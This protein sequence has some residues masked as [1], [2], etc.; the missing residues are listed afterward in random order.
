MNRL[1]LLCASL[2]AACG[3]AHEDD[4]NPAPAPEARYDLCADAVVP[5]GFGLAWQ[6][7]NHRIS[8]WEIRVDPSR[9]ERCSGDGGSTL[10]ATYVGGDWT[11]GQS[12][13]DVPV[14]ML[15]Y[16]VVAPRDPN[17]AVRKPQQV[18]ATH[19][20][21]PL[22]IDPSQHASTVA[23]RAASEHPR[24]EVLTGLELDTDVPQDAS[25][26]D[27]YDP[28]HG[29]TSRG[30]TARVTDRAD[31]DVD[32][33]VAFEH[34]EA[35]RPPMN[36]A[37]EHARTRAVVGHTTLEVPGG[38][39]TRATKRIRLTYPM[40]EALDPTP[41]P[42]GDDAS[43]STLIEG[44]PGYDHGMV[45]LTGVSFSLFPELPYGDYI[46]E[47]SVRPRK[48][49]YD[50]DTGRARLLL[51]GYASN[52]GFLTMAGMDA[53]MTFDLVLV[54]WNGGDRPVQVSFSSP[55]DTGEAAFALPM[56]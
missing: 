30:I 36:A 40:Q 32:V 11:T 34:G 51:D 39:F 3:S 41:L 31:G 19:R 54:Q 1:V 24:V 4:P 25:Y 56:E 42:H 52:S 12:A 21:T 43:L 53:D 46:R 18:R 35:D 17:G 16:V 47:L 55:F 8:R 5:N 29:Y 48:V 28:A 33:Q 13:T 15:D 2:L 10:H 50:P 20:S 44:V 23:E 14:V 22:D 49:R 37:I 27:D 45:L 6:N 7:L 26:P 38:R 9:A